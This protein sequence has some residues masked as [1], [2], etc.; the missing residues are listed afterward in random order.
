MRIEIGHS[1]LKRSNGDS[2][3][4][5][6]IRDSELKRSN[7]DSDSKKVIRDSQLK[8]EIENIIQNYSNE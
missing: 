8:R 7:G 5:I 6:E 3:F 2:E 4:K 1:A